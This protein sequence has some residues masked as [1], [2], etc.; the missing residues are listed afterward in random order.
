MWV[1]R[2][3]SRSSSNLTASQSMEATDRRHTRG[4]LP[5]IGSGHRVCSFRT[6]GG[7]ITYCVERLRM[8]TRSQEAVMVQQAFDFLFTLA[9]VA[10]PAAV[11]ICAALLAV[12]SRRHRTAHTARAAA[13]A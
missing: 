8:S 9:L 10:P 12:P 3:L 1:A 13:H 7:W 5:E 4:V 11:I 6:P 2:N